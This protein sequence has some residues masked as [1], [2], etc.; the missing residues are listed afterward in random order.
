MY[1]TVLHLHVSAVVSSK[2]VGVILYIVSGFFALK[3]AQTNRS[4]TVGFVCAVIWAVLT[5]TVA[6]TKQPFLFLA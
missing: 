2:V 1:E 3:W 5:A 4:R 6:F